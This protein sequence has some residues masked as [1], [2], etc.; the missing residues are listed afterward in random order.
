MTTGRYPV[1]DYLPGKL[2]TRRSIS[3]WS[4]Q[5]TVSRP[6]RTLCSVYRDPAMCVPLARDP[7]ALPSEERDGRQRLPD[8]GHD[9][10]EVIGDERP[11]LPQGGFLLRRPPDATLDE[12]PGVPEVH[13]AWQGLEELPRDK[14]DDRLPAGPPGEKRGGRLL[15][16]GPRLAEQYDGLRLRVSLEHRQEF[17][18][19]GPDEQIAADRHVGALADARLGERH[20]HLGAHSAATGD[21]ADRARV[22]HELR[23]IAA[24]PTNLRF[25]GTDDALGV[26]AHHPHSDLGGA[27]KDLGRV[28]VGDTLGQDHHERDGGLEG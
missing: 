14:G 4:D 28:V 23:P 2:Q 13:A 21:D 9:L 27:S 17:G 1:T 26:R 6:W 25:A 19:L 18:E 7:V 15:T 12:R 24:R 22:E 10:L 5:E 20:G 16:A 11:R 8:E 3:Q